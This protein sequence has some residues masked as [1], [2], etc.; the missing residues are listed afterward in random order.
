MSVAEFYDSKTFDEKARKLLCKHK[1]KFD[2]FES[3]IKDLTKQ[4]ILKFS[5]EVTVDNFI[6][7]N[8]LGI[9]GEECLKM[10]TAA[11]H[12]DILN[13]CHDVF[14]K[15]KDKKKRLVWIFGPRNTG[16]T[17]FIRLPQIPTTP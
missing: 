3:N 9:S 4:N 7:E 15:R 11:G 16:K 1:K 8:P 10:I 5:L 2:D 17:S 14:F 6:Q 12:L 13:K